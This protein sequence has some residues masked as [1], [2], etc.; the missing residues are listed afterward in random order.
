[1]LRIGHD[2]GELFAE[3]VPHRDP[4]A[5]RTLDHDREALIPGGVI[6]DAFYPMGYGNPGV[7]L[8]ILSE[9]LSVPLA[10]K[11]KKPGDPKPRIN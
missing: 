5:S 8:R 2:H 9:I 10:G 1:V 6:A 3:H 11:D 7:L 4:A